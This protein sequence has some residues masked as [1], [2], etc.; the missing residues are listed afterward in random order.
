MSVI[1]FVVDS[2]ATSHMINVKGALH[3]AKPCNTLV[4]I[5]GNQ[6]LLAESI[7][8][9]TGKLMCVDGPVHIILH[10]VMFV[11]GLRSCLLSTQKSTGA[12]GKIL[13]EHKRMI[14]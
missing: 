2:G 6:S 10:D 3:N 13:L 5:R 1:N 12:G 11:P 7:G 8:C 14:I 9:I 4:L